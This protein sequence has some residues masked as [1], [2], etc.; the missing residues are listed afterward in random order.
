[1][2]CTFNE[3][4]GK[5]YVSRFMSVL[6]SSFIIR[7]MEKKVLWKYVYILFGHFTTA[8]ASKFKRR[9]TELEETLYFLYRL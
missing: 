6:F 8:C 9:N 7:K 4:Q 2:Y 5:L 3:V 1:M